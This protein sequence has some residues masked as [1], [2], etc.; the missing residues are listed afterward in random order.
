MREHRLRATLNALTLAVIGAAGLAYATASDEEHQ[1]KVEEPVF[2]APYV[3]YDYETTPT[4]DLTWYAY[5]PQAY[6]TPTPIPP[7]PEPTRAPVFQHNPPQQS[8]P[9]ECP[10]LIVEAWGD[11][12]AAFACQ[13]AR[14]ESNWRMEALGS[15]GERGMM[16][17]APIHDW[18]FG[19]YFG[20]AANP[21]DPAQHV[22]VAHQ[23]WLEQGWAPWSCA[24]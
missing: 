15:A 7:T 11:E 24:R 16:Q 22:Y 19:A 2:A 3:T 1:L 12:H 21:W 9:G 13:V 10:A 17:L 6:Q 18:R 8:P 14:C 5:S 4:I 23:I 20:G